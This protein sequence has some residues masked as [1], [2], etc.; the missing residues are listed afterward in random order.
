MGVP[1]QVPFSTITLTTTDQST[2]AQADETSSDASRLNL[3]GTIIPIG[4]AVLGLLC[5]IAAALLARRASP[6][7]QTPVS[8][9]DTGTPVG[10]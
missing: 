1:I 4:L 10:V 6:G 5:L 3:Y 2:Q 9:Q 8:A 7:G